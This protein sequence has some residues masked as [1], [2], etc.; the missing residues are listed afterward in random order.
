MALAESTMLALNSP[1]PSFT[2]TTLDGKNFDSNTLDSDKGI[3]VAVICNH[4]PF[5]LHIQDKMTELFNHWQNLGLKV[6]AIS[7]NDPATHPADSP[8]KMAVV[9]KKQGYQF[10][11]LFDESQKV[12]KA[13]KAVCTPEF[14]LYNEDQ[15]LVYRGQFD[16][17]RPGNHDKITGE[18]LKQAVDT[19]LDG[20][21]LSESIV[22]KPSIGCNIKWK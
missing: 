3:V 2:L 12:V 10:P 6:I 19:L 5:V 16:N 8:E 21:E 13:F 7:A 1:L 22:Q 18:S 4:C 9:A 14:Y 15:K 20:K 11:Y 17:S